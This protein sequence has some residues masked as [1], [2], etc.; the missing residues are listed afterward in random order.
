MKKT[1]SLLLALCILTFAALPAFAV[2]NHITVEPLRYTNIMN[3]QVVIQRS[4]T[5]GVCTGNVN[6]GSAATT[7]MVLY[8]QISYDDGLTYKDYYLVASEDF[9]GSGSF[10]I[11]GSKQYLPSNYAYRAALYISVYDE[12]G[13]LIDYAEKYSS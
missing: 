8:L 4:G 3:P 11:S 5:A 6:I 10:K 2:T 1:I 12:N 13:R 7:T 9:S